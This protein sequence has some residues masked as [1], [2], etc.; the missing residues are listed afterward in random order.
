MPSN[1]HLLNYL[2][3]INGPPK[4]QPTA[5]TPNLSSTPSTPSRPA[6]T[7]SSPHTIPSTPSISRTTSPTSSTCTSQQLPDLD[8]D[9]NTHSPS[10]KMSKTSMPST[11][12]DRQL[13]PRIPIN[14]IETLLKCLHGKPQVNTLHNISIPLLIINESEDSTDEEAGRNTLLGMVLY[15]TAKFSLLKTDANPP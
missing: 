8:E 3:A 7:P 9:S 4:L 14:Y 1:N 13:W 6:S 2:T 10:S 5:A 15:K 11:A 12:R